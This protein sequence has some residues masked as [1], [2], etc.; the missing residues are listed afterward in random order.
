VVAVAHTHL[1]A[2]HAGGAVVGGE[3]RFPNAVHHVHPADWAA[4]SERDDVE[5]YTARHA[6]DELERRGALEQRA[7]DH[8]VAAGVHVTWSPG[9][10]PGHRSVLV[11]SGDATALLT[12]D[13]LHIPTQVRLPRAPSSHDEDP[14]AA[15]ATRARV[16]TDAREHGW[17]VGVPHFAHP[18][19]RVVEEGW[20]SA[21]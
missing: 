4:F 3:P 21:G 19:G 13:A 16:L 5:G 7:D 20:R 8:D 9:H 2:D 18:F 14:D 6:M 10:T 17:V 11:R 15:C 1:H 12:G